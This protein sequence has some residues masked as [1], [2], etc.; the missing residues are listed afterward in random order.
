MKKL[1][2]ATQVFGVIAMFPFVMI[3]ELN[4]SN[5]HSTESNSTSIFKHHVEM[6]NIC[7]IE[8]ATGKLEKDVF[9]ATAEIVIVQAFKK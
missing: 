1:V 8:N 6:K 5:V 7:F 3:L 4:R 9:P 2:F